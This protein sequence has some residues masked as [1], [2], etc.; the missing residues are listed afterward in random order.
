MD[1]RL[2]AAADNAALRR[3]VFLSLGI[4]ALAGL[5][6]AGGLAA[7]TPPRLAKGFDPCIHVD[8]VS[9]ASAPVVHRNLP[10]VEPAALKRQS[11][12]RTTPPAQP[13]A[14]TTATATADPSP[15]EPQRL[16]AAPASLGRGLP[17][18]HDRTGAGGAAVAPPGRL[19]PLAEV[20]SG[21]AGGR[22]TND[23]ATSLATPR[24]RENPHP[25]YPRLSRLR[26][27]EGVVLLTVEVLP[28][29][30]VGRLKVK[31]SSG[32]ELLD[33]SALAGM[34]KWTFEPGR[35]L[36]IPVAMWVDVPIRF[37]LQ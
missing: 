31:I 28:S 24:Y 30:K 13:A 10:P 5:L 37:H 26:G 6:L 17:A 29:G 18:G 15:N 21:P 32:Y 4:H 12:A 8:L 9:L 7:S 35:K 25:D 19:A 14:T 11:D 2:G 33:R 36:G 27:H 20:A 22:V 3:G 16:T 1:L 34:K 23:A